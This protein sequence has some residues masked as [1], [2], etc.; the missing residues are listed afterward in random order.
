MR[1]RYA[2]CCLE[3]WLEAVKRRRNGTERVRRG[4][5][6]DVVLTTPR[7]RAKTPDLVPS[8][9][10]IEALGQAACQPVV[11]AVQASPTNPRLP[12]RA[13]PNCRYG[14]A[15]KDA[16]RDRAW[17]LAVFAWP[18]SGDGSSAA[19]RGA[20][21]PM[22]WRQRGLGRSAEIWCQT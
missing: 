19:D 21:L 1:S 11:N 3:R 7:R 4:R 14:M 13:A 15:L 20:S 5:A 10:R 18:E 22:A 8:P 9:P 16:L 6:L 2:A 12:P 17:S